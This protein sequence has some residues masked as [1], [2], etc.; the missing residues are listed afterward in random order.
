MPGKTKPVSVHPHAG[1]VARACRLIEEA[2][3][4]PAL[5]PLARAVAMSPSHFHRVFKSLTGLS[6]KAYATA[7]RAQR[8]RNELSRGGSV[9]AALYNAGYKS[10]GRFYAVSSRILGMKPSSF[11][12]GGRGVTIQFAVGDCSLGSILVAASAIGVCS[13]ALGDDPNALVQHLQDQFPKARLVGGDRKFERMV[14]RVIA[15]VERPAQGLGL[16][17]DVQ[18][19]AFQQRVWQQLRRIPCGETRS[20]AEIANALGKPT[21]TR[22]VASACAANRIAV[23]IPCHR[24][25]RT[26]GTLSGYRWGV[27]RKAKLLQRERG[28]P[29]PAPLSRR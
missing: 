10:N 17:L 7:H 28:A 18:G 4:A 11:R 16:P 2:D 5:E 6:P 3:E 25:V 27:E 26:D 19:T 23:A 1:A 24:V 21:A 12:A 9:T 8:V 20:Y 29:S 15:F 22:A 14:A 13:I